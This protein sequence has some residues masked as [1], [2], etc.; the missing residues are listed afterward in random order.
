[1]RNYYFLL[2]ILSTCL[3]TSCTIGKVIYVTPE[4][5]IFGYYNTKGNHIEKGLYDSLVNTGDY[6]PYTLAQN[7]YSEARLI[8]KEKDYQ[9]TVQE[10]ENLKMY[11]AAITEDSIKF[12]RPVIFRYYNVR[13]IHRKPVPSKWNTKKLNADI[14]TMNSG[15]IDDRYGR[16]HHMLLYE[17]RLMFFPKILYGAARIPENLILV[18]PDGHLYSVV[19]DCSIEKAAEMLKRGK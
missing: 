17:D 2:L 16:I 10:F 4:I 3:I 7:E 12:D 11:I 18:I 19:G 14:I 15:P 13:G 9:L 6:V 1:M 8:E 5:P